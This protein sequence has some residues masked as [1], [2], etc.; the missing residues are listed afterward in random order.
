MGGRLS[1]FTSVKPADPRA[2]LRDVLQ[3][4]GADVAWLVG[5]EDFGSS[6]WDE[7]QKG[8]PAASRTTHKTGPVEIAVT[9]APVAAK[10]AQNVPIDN[11][12]GMYEEPWGLLIQFA[13]SPLGTALD[14]E[15]RAAI[16]KAIRGDCIPSAPVVR[17][18]WHDIY[19][20]V[21]HKEGR[22]YGRAFLSFELEG[23]WYPKNWAAFR[24]A[25]FEIPGVVELRRR[26]E[27]VVGPVDQCVV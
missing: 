12:A 3:L 13:G 20:S 14:Q 24:N 27:A 9:Q 8:L 1:F 5:Q 4:T 10:N 6:S 26:L 21:E 7:F 17:M 23:E 15:I 18:G 22:Y 25:L 16:P 2:A 11:V 19:S